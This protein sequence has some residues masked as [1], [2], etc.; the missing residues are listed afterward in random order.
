[1]LAGDAMKQLEIED[2]SEIAEI[3]QRLRKLWT[4]AKTGHDLDGERLQLTVLFPTVV[5]DLEQ[6][7]GHLVFEALEPDLSKRARPDENAG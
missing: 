6:Q 5:K 2:R 3:V 4:I 1:L 7:L